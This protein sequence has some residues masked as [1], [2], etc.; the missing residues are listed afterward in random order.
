[1][2]LYSWGACYLNVKIY[3]HA[4]FKYTRNSRTIIYS[5]AINARGSITVQS[6]FLYFLMVFFVVV[7]VVGFFLTGNQEGN[8]ELFFIK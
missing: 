4:L 3:C 5:R 6:M 7:V 8:C 2:Y 1:M